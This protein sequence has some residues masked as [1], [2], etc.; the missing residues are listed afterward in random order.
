[1]RSGCDWLWSEHNRWDQM[2][3]TGD[4]HTSSP[5]CVS[6]LMLEV[7]ELQSECCRGWNRRHSSSVK[8][9]FL[10]FVDNPQ[11]PQTKLLFSTFTLKCNLIIYSSRSRTTKTHFETHIS[12]KFSTNQHLFFKIKQLNLTPFFLSKMIEMKQSLQ[13]KFLA[14]K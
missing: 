4:T 8:L 3:I 11:E 6:A 12:S 2:F 10:L 1:M 13:F 9:M 7:L 5:R 14:A